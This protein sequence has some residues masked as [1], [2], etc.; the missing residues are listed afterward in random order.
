M[1]ELFW[2]RC[3]YLSFSFYEDETRGTREES[4]VKL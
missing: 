3:D 2:L 1:L 4:K